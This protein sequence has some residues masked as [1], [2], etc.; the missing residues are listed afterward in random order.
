MFSIFIS[1][2]STVIIVIRS[3]VAITSIA[4]VTTVTRIVAAGIV[5]AIV[6]RDCVTS[7]CQFVCFF[8]YIGRLLAFR[9]QTKVISRSRS[10][11]CLE[12]IYR[13]SVR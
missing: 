2:F 6:T 8:K 4:V 3:V 5:A 12:I 9:H 11:N 10:K 1:I 13:F 7:S